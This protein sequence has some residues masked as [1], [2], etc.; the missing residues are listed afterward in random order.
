MG[1]ISRSE[2]DELF[3]SDC[4]LN[5]TARMVLLAYANHIN[6]NDGAAEA[7]PSLATVACF[8]GINRNSASKYVKALHADGWLIQGET[9]HWSDKFNWHWGYYLGHGSTT[10][11]FL[12]RREPH[13]KGNVTESKDSDA[14][15]RNKRCRQTQQAML[16]D[17]TSDADSVGMNNHRTTNEEPKNHHA[18]D[19]LNR[20]SDVD[21]SF[22]PVQGSGGLFKLVNGS[23]VKSTASRGSTDADRRNIAIDESKRHLYRQ[24]AADLAAERERQAEQARA[25]ALAAPKYET[26]EDWL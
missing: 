16:T 19:N 22:N 24:A 25:Y 21:P 23:L 3:R 8:A 17:A 7:Y 10:H 4:D 9:Q 6:Y 14:D 13:N 1:A 11:K 20:D 12:K 5:A 15:R 2:L 26:D 18:G